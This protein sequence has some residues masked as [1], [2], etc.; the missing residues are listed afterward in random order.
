MLLM[1]VRSSEGLLTLK[2]LSVRGGKL[3]RLDD[4]DVD[5]A[6]CFRLNDG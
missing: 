6:A 3:R 2:K 1:D 4:G 5:G